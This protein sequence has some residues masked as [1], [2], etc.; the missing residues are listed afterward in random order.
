MNRP[1]SKTGFAIGMILLVI[2]AIAE[3]NGYSGFGLLMIIIA[4]GIYIFGK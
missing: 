4:F 2:G 3:L 1:L